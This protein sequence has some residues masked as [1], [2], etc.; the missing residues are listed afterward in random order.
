MADE[1]PVINLNGIER[2]YEQGEAT[3]DLEPEAGNG[4]P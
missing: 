1:T 3:L 2:R 4:N